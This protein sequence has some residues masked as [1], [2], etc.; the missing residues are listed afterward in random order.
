MSYIR[1]GLMILTSTVVMF[2]L[3][4]LNTYAWEHV[5]FSETRT[6]MAI[7][8][9]AAMAIIMLAYMLGMY[10]NRALNIAIFAGS[11]IVFAL[12]LW[13]VRSQVTV[14]GT[15]YMRAMIPHHSIAIMTSE[16]AQIRDPRV[17]KLADEIIEAQRR[18]IAEM[19]YLIGEVS[20]GNTVENIYRD[21]PAEPGTVED[22]L[23]N[24]LISTLDLAPMPEA[25]A[26]RVLTAADRCTFNRSPEADPVLWA[27]EDGSGAAMK[28]N[29]VLV[30]LEANGDPQS[31]AVE[32]S[33]PGTTISVLS[34][35]N[36]ADW[37]QNAELVFRLDQGFEVGY[38]GFYRCGAS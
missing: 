34:L 16:R 31:G 15:S 25:E 32:F 1:F 28:L 29:G 38:R 8:M 9:G 14:L 10:S 4:Y 13:L 12:S 18:E 26:D 33:A 21:P 20:E 5:F 24:T 36:E 22:A 30:S 23:A 6:Y 19:R 3:M 35:G 37:R 17:R 27:A 2:I 11:V 7:M